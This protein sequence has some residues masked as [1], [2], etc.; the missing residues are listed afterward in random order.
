M[1]RVLIWSD[2]YIISHFFDLL[3]D[4]K[5]LGKLFLAMLSLNYPNPRVRVRVKDLLIK[6]QGF[7]KK[8]I[9]GLKLNG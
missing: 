7:D 6:L 3:S 9:L 8:V 1:S 5:N 2:Q 4:K